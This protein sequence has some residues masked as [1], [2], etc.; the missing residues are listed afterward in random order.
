MVV[1]A[2]LA[3]YS[4]RLKESELSLSAL[5]QTSSSPPRLR[6]ASA[7]VTTRERST[8]PT[9][10]TEETELLTKAS[11]VSGPFPCPSL[12]PAHATGSKRGC[13]GKI[14]LGKKRE[15]LWA[16]STL[17]SSLR[18]PSLALLPLLRF[19]GD[20]GTKRKRGE[21]ARHERQCVRSNTDSKRRARSTT[22][23][24]VEQSFRESTRETQREREGSLVLVARSPPSLKSGG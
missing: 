23:V 8:G 1:L 14:G 12:A 15:V 18:S 17:S 10:A 3:F 21:R 16:Q 9:E 22:V 7:R 4:K 6:F 5:P 13:P 19:I 20:L 11:A 2:G 24:C